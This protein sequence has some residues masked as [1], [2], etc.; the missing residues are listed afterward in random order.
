MPRRS[1]L[2]TGSA[3]AVAAAGL[4]GRGKGAGSG[5]GVGAVEDMMREHGVL[6]RAL[7]AYTETAARLR[8]NEGQPTPGLSTRAPEAGGDLVPHVR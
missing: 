7:F 6:R 5:K 2:H 4:A 8:G 1:F 3:G